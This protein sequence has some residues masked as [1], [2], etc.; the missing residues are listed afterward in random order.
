METVGGNRAFSQ[1][2]NQQGGASLRQWNVHRATSSGCWMLFAASICHSMPLYSQFPGAQLQSKGNGSSRGSLWTS[3]WTIAIPQQLVLYFLLFFLI[4][5]LRSYPR[6]IQFPVSL[7]WKDCTPCLWTR[8]IFSS[9]IS[10][11]NFSLKPN[12]SS[13]WECF[14]TS[15]LYNSNVCAFSC[16]E[17]V[18]STSIYLSTDAQVFL[19]QKL[20]VKRPDIP[21]SLLKMKDDG[22]EEEE[23]EEEME[24]E[25]EVDTVN[26]RASNLE[27]KITTEEETGKETNAPDGSPCNNKN[28]ESL[29]DG[30]PLGLIFPVMKLSLL[31]LNFSEL[32]ESPKVWIT[33]SPADFFSIDFCYE[34]RV[35]VPTAEFHLVPVATL[36]GSQ[37]F[38]LLVK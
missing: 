24:E 25:Q 15:C 34:S 27:M 10:T 30:K 16:S 36:L 12:Y 29:Q 26:S 23:E 28:L 18:T 1:A 19:P 21:E 38:M 20:P 22:L 37:F 9:S 14:L 2:W 7:L 33:G 6:L 13:S 3:G 31:L 35:C 5:Q 8:H 32:C 11:N 4:L 17:Y